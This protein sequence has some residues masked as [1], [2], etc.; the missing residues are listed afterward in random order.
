MIASRIAVIT[1]VENTL[2]LGFWKDTLMRLSILVCAEKVL[3]EQQCTVANAQS[4]TGSP[5]YRSRPAL[6]TS[7]FR[8]LN[9]FF[10][11]D[12]KSKS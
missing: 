9:R 4:R 10:Y 8:P 6:A 7:I 3:N 12:A 11:I 2:N 5:C 1:T